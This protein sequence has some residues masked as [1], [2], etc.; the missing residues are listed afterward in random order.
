MDLFRCE[1]P[2]FSRAGKGDASRFAD[3]YMKNYRLTNKRG[4]ICIPTGNHDMER[5]RKYLDEQEMKMAYT[6][7]MSMPGVPFIY[8]GDEIGMRQLSVP[9]VEG[10][11]D[12]TGA[13]T[14]MQWDYKRNF[15]FSE[16]LEEMLYTSQDTAG[17]VSAV[18]DQIN[19]NE[20]LWHEVQKL[21]GIRSS[22]KALCADGDIAFVYCQPYKYPFVYLRSTKEEK[23]LVILNPSREKASCECSFT[24]GKVIYSL[25]GN[26]TFENGKLYVSGESAAFISIQ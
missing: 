20:S 16:A 18:S 25:G 3:T 22:H 7:L 15:G 23:I 2:Y 5:M 1:H 24:P 19:D 4:L 9:S 26:I 11:Y 13:R 8:Y 12:R 6:F 21:I 10:G 14:P 17:D